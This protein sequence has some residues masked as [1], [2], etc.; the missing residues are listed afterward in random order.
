MTYFSFKDINEQLLDE[1]IRNSKLFDIDEAD[2]LLYLIMKDFISAPKE[3][4]KLLTREDISREESGSPV[5]QHLIKYASRN[6]ENQKDISQGIKSVRY[7]SYYIL[8]FS[9][10]KNIIGQM[11]MDGKLGS[12][13]NNIYVIFLQEILPMDGSLQSELDEPKTFGESASQEDTIIAILYNKTHT[14]NQIKY[15][16]TSTLIHEINHDYDRT[17]FEN[18]SKFKETEQFS[19]I[20]K[21]QNIDQE[22]QLQYI[23]N[24]M[25]TRYYSSLLSEQAKAGIIWITRVW[26]QKSIAKEFI[27][28]CEYNS[29]DYSNIYSEQVTHTLHEWL[30]NLMTSKLGVLRIIDATTL[31]KDKDA[32]IILYK[33]VFK[34]VKHGIQG[35]LS[36]LIKDKDVR[37]R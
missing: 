24:I 7:P 5:A 37:F 32:L 23:M 4:W 3:Y 2:E 13:L 17:N 29:V 10:D 19:S 22:K 16:L 25:N 20:N 27:R 26:E 34:Y 6:E 12:D 28:Y 9:M 30:A 31:E 8:S 35:I 1:G 15:I 36:R 33:R 14:L 18:D 11:K 21:T